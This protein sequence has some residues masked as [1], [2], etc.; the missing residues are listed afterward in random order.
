M[1]ETFDCLHVCPS[2]PRGDQ[3]QPDNPFVIPEDTPLPP[4]VEVETK[5]DNKTL[6]PPGPPLFRPVPTGPKP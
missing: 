1:T 6:F 4:G 5:K 2:A 3:E